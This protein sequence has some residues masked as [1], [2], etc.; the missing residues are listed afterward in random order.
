MPPA[1]ETSEINFTAETE[2]T[3]ENKII[4]YLKLAFVPFGFHPRLAITNFWNY[5]LKL[6]WNLFISAILG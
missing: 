6:F 2:I 1:N 5:G 4:S 3:S